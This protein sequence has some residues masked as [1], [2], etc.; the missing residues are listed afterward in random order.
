MYFFASFRLLVYLSGLHTQRGTNFFQQKFGVDQVWGRKMGF[1]A[2]TPFLFLKAS[3]KAAAQSSA[4][5]CFG[6]TNAWKGKLFET[7]AFPTLV[8]PPSKLKFA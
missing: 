4:E 1:L 7:F 2:V 8:L 6:C 5:I 3:T